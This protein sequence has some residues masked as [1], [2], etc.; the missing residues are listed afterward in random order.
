[1]SLFAN[2]RRQIATGADQGDRR[3]KPFEAGQD[4]LVQDQE[5]HSTEDQTGYQQGY[6]E[7][8]QAGLALLIES[9][10]HVRAKNQR[11]LTVD[12]VQ[13]VVT[14]NALFTQRSNRQT[15]GVN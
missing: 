11:R 7:F 12:V 5:R 13:Q 9:A 14:R 4:Q 15:L 1:M 3:A 10:G 6:D 2:A 8:N